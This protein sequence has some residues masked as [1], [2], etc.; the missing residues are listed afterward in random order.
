MR[1]PQRISPG[2]RARRALMVDAAAAIVLAAV[3][4]YLAAGLGVVGFF[5]LP[6][7]VLGLVWIATERLLPRVRFRRRRAA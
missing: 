3:V 2:A 4:L 6:I 1:A 7:L 5:G